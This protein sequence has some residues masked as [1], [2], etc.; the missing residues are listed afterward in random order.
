MESWLTKKWGIG[1][2]RLRTPGLE[3]TSS[4][5]SNA[6][7][8]LPVVLQSKTDRVLKTYSPIFIDNC[9]KKCMGPYKACAPLSTGNLIVTCSGAQHV[10]T[11]LSCKTL[12]D[13]NKTVEVETSSL[14]P[15]GAKGV[16][17]NVPLEISTDEIVEGLAG[18]KVTFV[19][20]FRF[21]C[22]ESSEFRDSKSVFLQF[23]TADLPAEVKLGYL[24]FRVKQF[25]PKPLRCFK[26]NRFRHVASHCRGRERCSTCGGEHKYS[27]CTAD[28]AKCPNCGGNHS[29]NDKTCP[30]YQRETEI[31]KLKT[32]S[33]LSYA[34]ACKEFIKSRDTPAPNMQSKSEFPLLPTSTRRQS[35]ARSFVNSTQIGLE[36]SVSLQQDSCLSLRL[37]GTVVAEQMDFS[38]LLFG[39]PVA[40][41]AFLA[42]V[43]QTILAKDK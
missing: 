19:K 4:K 12:L 30:R 39:D 37:D 10:K 9:L 23:S 17:Y 26:C 28:T 24:L 36:S 41:L 22:K 29:A 38:S 11:L 18:Q 16:I 43:K 15:V 7:E 42:D 14:K 27:E 33:K 35:N 5:Q 2:K 8:L 31:L 3:P 13:G 34:N 40:F 20:R 1:E 32:K 25:I 21:R 6:V